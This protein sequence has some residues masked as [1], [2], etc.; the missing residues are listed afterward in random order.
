M[1]MTRITLSIGA[2]LVIMYVVAFLVYASASAMA[3]LQP[4]QGASPATFLLSVLVTKVGLALAFVLL[5]YLARETWVRHW[6]LYALV[7]WVMF[8]LSEIGQAIGP[9]YSWLEATAG[10]VAESIYCPL[11]A[12]VVAKLVGTSGA[13]PATP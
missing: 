3:G 9:A 12:F 11:A 4:P 1:S 10:I 6:S 5:F 13:V 7:W 2:T 8:A